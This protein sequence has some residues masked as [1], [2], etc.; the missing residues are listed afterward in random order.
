MT[1]NPI[2]ESTHL[3][4][5]IRIAAADRGADPQHVLPIALNSLESAQALDYELLS[6]DREEPRAPSL[7]PFLPPPSDRADANY[8]DGMY[9]TIPGVPGIR[10]IGH[11]AD[12]KWPERAGGGTRE[13]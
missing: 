5:T 2:R 13:G 8:A 1:D 11:E 10:S 9:A 7:P 6:V 3:V 4:V 12:M